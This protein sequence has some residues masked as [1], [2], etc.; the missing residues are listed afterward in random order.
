M[1]NKKV[2]LDKRYLPNWTLQNC[3]D[4]LKNGVIGIIEYHLHKDGSWIGYEF[5]SSEDKEVKLKELK[6]SGY[7]YDKITYFEPLKIR[8]ETLT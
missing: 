6:Q 2:K 3:I 1:S 8:L 5:T 7:V 4:Y